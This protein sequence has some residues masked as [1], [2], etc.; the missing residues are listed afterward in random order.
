ML[1]S[2]RVAAIAVTA[3][4]ALAGCGGDDDSATTEAPTVTT[5]PT[6]APA[7]T[8]APMELT[9]SISGSG[10]SF[11]DAFEQAVIE[12]FLAGP[13]AGTDVTYQ[14]VGSGT[15]KTD[16]ISG[17]T[18]FAGTDS[19][20]AAD[21]GI[22]PD[23]FVYVPISGAP[24]TVSYNLSG[25]DSLQL[26]AA[27]LANIFD[28]DI[29]VWNDPAI[30]ADNP[31]VDLPDTAITVAHRSDGSGT[32]NRFTEFLTVA[33]PNDWALGQGD[34]VAWAADTQGGEKNTGV[35]QIITSTDG[36]IGYVDL[37]DAQASGLVFA[38]IQNQDGEYVAPTL[39]GASAAWAGAE[40]PADMTV[41]PINGAGADTYPIT[42]PTYI[43]LRTH[44]DDPD[45][46]ALV[47]AYAT[48]LLTEGQ[49]LAEDIGFTKLPDA[50]QTASLAQVDKVS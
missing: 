2:K 28:R 49:N 43:L 9:G 23:E 26:S 17:L 42:A 37:S 7:T 20:V 10:S 15:G 46:A 1:T 5:A 16:F 50:V 31:G 30:A 8:E 35:A 32:T 27:T 14:A 4:M 47:K 24:I 13:G 41:D 39:A 25:V 22:S 6:E 48:F 12:A 19:L 45:T 3:A 21:A 29:T 36:A 44:Y 40:V 33:A 18:D 34:T 38:S 11:Q